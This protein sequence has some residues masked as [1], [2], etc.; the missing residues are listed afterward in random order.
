MG[1]D[2]Q[3][4]FTSF[5]RTP[6]ASASIGQVHK[7][8]LSPS[9]SPTGKPMEVAVKIQFP[10]IMNSIESDL[11]YVRWLLTAGRVLPPGMFL[12]KS[13]AALGEELRLECDYKREAESLQ[14]FYTGLTGKEA[15]RQKFQVPWVWTG[16]TRE[17]LVM[18]FLPGRAIGRISTEKM[19]QTERDDIASRVLELCL[20]ELFELRMMQTDPNWSNFLWNEKERRL[21]LV[22][23]GATRE[24]SAEFM[25]GWLKLLQSA[26]DNDYDGCVEGSLRLGYLTGKEEKVRTIGNMFVQ[27]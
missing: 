8:T 15:D 10:N 11:S 13:A 6:F 18:E 23:F 24:Y 2:W 4:S 3:D 25:D 21:G 22:D 19:S 14:K 20:R 27:H 1:P 26:A 7:A 16:S 17:V 12:E 5:S 9:L